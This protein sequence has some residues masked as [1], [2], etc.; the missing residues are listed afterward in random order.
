MGKR[1]KY[2]KGIQIGRE[3][4]RLSLFADEIIL[5]LQNLTALTQKLLQLINNFSKLS[6]YNIQ[7]AQYS[8]TPTIAKLRAKSE[9][10]RGTVTISSETISNNTKR[11]NPSQIIIFFWREEKKGKKRSEEEEERGRKRGREDGNIALF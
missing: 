6:G 5:Y 2:I 10:Q 7:K 4:V 11:G 1:N 8:Y 3:E 9:T